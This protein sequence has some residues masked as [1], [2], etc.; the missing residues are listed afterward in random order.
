VTSGAQQCIKS[1]KEPSVSCLLLSASL[2]IN[3]C[4]YHLY[5]CWP[6]CLPVLDDGSLVEQQVPGALVDVAHDEVVLTSVQ[7]RSTAGTERRAAGRRPQT[8]SSIDCQDVCGGTGYAAMWVVQ[9]LPNDDA[10]NRPRFT[11]V[12]A[13]QLNAFRLLVRRA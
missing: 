5:V 8:D 3:D 13:F 7:P 4:H 1:K 10:Y 9:H 12:S 11:V 2:L 6:R